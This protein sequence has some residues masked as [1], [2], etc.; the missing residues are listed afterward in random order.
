MKKIGLTFL[1]LLNLVAFSF[2]QEYSEIIKKAGTAY[3]EKD[4]KTS[5]KAYK[6]AFKIKATN[7]S[8]LYNAACS[9]ALAGNKKLGNK[10]L[11]ASIEN[12]WTNLRHMKSDSDLNNLHRTKKWSKS[13]TLLEEKLAILEAS[14]DQPLRKTLLAILDEDQKYRH[15]TDSV[16]AQ[17]GRNSKELKALW[18]IINEKDSI[19]LIKVTNI[20]DEHGWVGQSKVG[21]EGA[22]ALFLVIQHSDKETQR[23]YIPMFREAVKNKEASGGSLALMEDRLLLGDGKLQIYGSQVWTLPD[24]ETGEKIEFFPPMIDPDNVDKRR[25]EVG[26][27]DLATYANYF[28]MTW[29]LEQYKKDLPK[30]QKMFDD[31][32][33]ERA[34]KARP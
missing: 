28:G 26:L 34:K 1:L 20:I 11:K 18:K 13:V 17:F 31:Y 14:Y 21:N 23:K 4:Y 24:P 8:D 16:E 25:A 33:T 3:N 10:Y 32:H 2:A 22:T 27:P 12:G 15:M 9:A 7:R 30:L 6:K 29:D 19:N 5:Y